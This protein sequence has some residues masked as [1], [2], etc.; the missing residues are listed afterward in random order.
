MLTDEP[1]MMLSIVSVA[2]GYP[3]RLAYTVYRT[4]C[5][6]LDPLQMACMGATF[7]TESSS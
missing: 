2:T 6:P 7:E 4:P 5:C 1:D 3:C